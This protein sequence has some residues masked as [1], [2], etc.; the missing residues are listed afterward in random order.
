M[1]CPRCGAPS[2]EGARFCAACGATL[3]GAEKESAK[4]RSARDRVV[5]LIGKDRKSRTITAGT[6][7]ALIVALI[8]FIALEPDDSDEPSPIPRDAYTRTADR[9][10]I[11][12]KKEIAASESR[13][14]GAG[15]SAEP[16]EFAQSLV[17]VVLRWRTELASLAAPADRV[18]RAQALDGA[19]REVEVEISALARVAQEGDQK[20][21]VQRAKQVD[22]STTRVEA[23]VSELGLSRCARISL[24]VSP[25]ASG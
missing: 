9:I 22:E 14:L 13:S 18:E 2:E 16:G 17:P 6:V 7:L 20:Q 4:P 23:A 3:P 15:S 25:A 12:A 5:G 8:A 19:L 21:T 11:D 10:C 24:G 1:F